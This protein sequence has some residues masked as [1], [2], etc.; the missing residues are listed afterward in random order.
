MQHPKVLI[1][2]A[3]AVG[4]VYGYHLTKGGAKVTYF[5][6]E[7]YRAELADGMVLYPLKGPE[8]GQ[9]VRFSDYDLVTAADD[10]SGRGFDEMW[11]CVSSPALMTGWVDD[12]LPQ[13]GDATIMY[14]QAG[15]KDRH[16][17]EARVP[18]ERLCAGVIQMISWQAPL[19]TEDYDPP[20]IAY[21]WPRGKN[22][23]SGPKDRIGPIVDRLNRGGWGS[24]I[25]ADAQA[26]TMFMSVIMM[27]YMA[28]LEISD[29][30]F[31][32]FGKRGAALASQAAREARKIIQP[33]GNPVAAWF[34][35]SRFGL[36]MVTWM[37]P[38]IMPFDVE[39]YIRYHFTKV[40]D[41]TRAKLE[42]YQTLAQER[43]VDASGIKTLA[44]RLPPL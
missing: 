41:Q 19:E 32:E 4:A 26:Q 13:L 22:P 5:I 40:G 31:A 12:L 11:I 24:K 8:K 35:S 1:V 29:W 9:T 16:Y 42:H 10:L 27:P 15:L 7:K 20:G 3:G 6:K 18:P 17:M 2:G 25:V 43:G 39:T 34:L 14:M 28:G 33:G 23:F 38:K 21:W 30:R 36:R 44:N 37:M